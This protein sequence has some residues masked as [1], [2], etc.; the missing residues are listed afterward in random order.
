MDNAEVKRVE[1]HCHTKMSKMDALTPMEDLVKKQLNGGIKLL[2]L[3]TTVL[4]RHF[5]SAMMP[6]KAAI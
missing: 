4:C 2:L 1:L 3:P 6:Q 5:R